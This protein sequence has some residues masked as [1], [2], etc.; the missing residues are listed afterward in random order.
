MDRGSVD[1]VNIVGYSNNTVQYT[2]PL[3]SYSGMIPSMRLS[4]LMWCYLKRQGEESLTSNVRFND[5]H[6]HRR[7]FPVVFLS[8]QKC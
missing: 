8:G 5:A 3:R 6:V 2:F 1:M 7:P 4:M